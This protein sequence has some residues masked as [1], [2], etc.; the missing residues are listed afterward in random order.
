MSTIKITLVGDSGVGKTALCTSFTNGSQNRYFLSQYFIQLMRIDDQ[1]YTLCIADVKCSS[2]LNNFKIRKSFY[3]ESNV[4]A[5]CFALDNK[6]SLINA[7]NTWFEEAKEYA[8]DAIF[9][10]VGLKLDMKDS[11]PE[12]ER[13]NEAD[14]MKAKVDFGFLKYVNCSVV[15][16]TRINKVFK[17]A[18]RSYVNPIPE[19]DSIDMES[20]TLKRSYSAE[21]FGNE[22]KKK[23]KKKRIKVTYDLFTRQTS[24]SSLSNLF[25]T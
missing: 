16:G 24:T 15:Q 14:I 10:L 5:I 21:I 25:R 12:S 7:T 11:I 20:D 1:L 17:E 19:L 4:I 9:I 23:E 2:K 13:I 6:N 22:N 18:V 8:P 3:E